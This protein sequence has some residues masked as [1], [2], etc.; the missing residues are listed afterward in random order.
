MADFKCAACRIRLR[1]QGG[2]A[3]DRLCPVCHAPLESVG[4][5]S[6]IVG[7]RSIDVGPAEFEP[8]ARPLSDLTKRRDARLD[9]ERWLDDDGSFAR[10]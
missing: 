2:D 1:S 9:A 3:P 10:S 5:L 6:E 4:R 8:L 7:F